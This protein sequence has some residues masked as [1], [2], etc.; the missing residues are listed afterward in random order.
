MKTKDD[1]SRENSHENSSDKDKSDNRWMEGNDLSKISLQNE[2]FRNSDH[3]QYIAEGDA[4]GVEDSGEKC[5]LADQKQ[6]TSQMKQL[7]MQLCLNQCYTSH[8]TSLCTTF[9]LLWYCIFICAWHND[10][11]SSYR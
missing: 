3:Q 2:T 11:M 4:E 5:S 8:N 1:N 6:V 10:I 9:I 7:C